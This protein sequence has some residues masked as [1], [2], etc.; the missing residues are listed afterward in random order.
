LPVALIL[1]AIGCIPA[2]PQ[3]VFLPAAF[4]AFLLW[5]KLNRHEKLER[6][7]AA[8][9][10]APMLD[11]GRI[12]LEDVSDHTLVTVE[13]GYGLVQLVDENAARHWSAASRA[14]ASNSPRPS[15]SSSPSSACATVWTC[16]RAIIASCWAACCWAGQ[17][18][19]STGAGHRC[20]RG[21]PPC[22]DQGHRDARSFLRLPGLWI[23]PAL[24][25]MA[26]AEGYLAVDASTVIATH[27]NQLMGERPQLLLGPDEVKV[28]LEALKPRAGSL[29][30]TVYPTA[31]AG[32]DDA[33]L[34]NLLEDGIPIAHPCR[35]SPPSPR[36]CR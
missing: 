22:P 8:A 3:R 17:R 35:S 26:I 7:R 18:S 11:P 21:Q 36:R 27:L 25:D 24:R 20:G 9:G 16:S 4:V 10:A 6:A 14:C 19:W 15:A 23:D 30:E 32:G 29:V 33:L 13:L 31:D 28:L 2:M 5:R 34:R 12:T 1:A